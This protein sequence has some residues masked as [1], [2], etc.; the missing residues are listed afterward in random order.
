MFQATGKRTVLNPIFA[1]PS[2]NS[3]VM[4]GFPHPVSQMVVLSSVLPMLIPGVMSGTAAQASSSVIGSSAGG[5]ALPPV[6]GTASAEL[7][8]GGRRQATESAAGREG[9]RQE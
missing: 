2:T 6:A 3:L 5:F 1:S 9:R 8:G 4:S 7:S